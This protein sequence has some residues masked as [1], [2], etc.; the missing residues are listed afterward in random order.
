MKTKII[1]GVEYELETHDFNKILSEIKIPKGWRL[2]KPSEALMLLELEPFDDWFFVEQPLKN[3]TTVARFY[4]NSDRA[5]LNC[6]WSPASHVT[7]L[8][9]RFCRDVSAPQKAVQNNKVTHT[10]NDGCVSHSDKSPDDMPRTELALTKQGTGQSG[11]KPAL[12]VCICGHESINHEWSNYMTN[13]KCF[14]DGDIN[15][16]KCEKFEVKK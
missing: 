5:V 12:G 15:K 6:N 4:A 11:V 14:F 7:S 1:K 16:C 2:L 3:T 13:G 8:G 9:V 10:F